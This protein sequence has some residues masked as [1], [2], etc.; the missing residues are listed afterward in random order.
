MK[1]QNKPLL[2]I[3]YFGVGDLMF[4][5]IINFS[6][7]RSY[8]SEIDA[9][10]ILYALPGYIKKIG[11]IFV[12]VSLVI[13]V[14]QCFWG[15]KLYR[16]TIAISGFITGSI[17]GGAIGLM[18]SIGSSADDIKGTIS[19]VIFTMLI[20]GIIGA[21]VAYQAEALGIFLVGFSGVYAVSLI[22]SLMGKALTNSDSFAA[23]FFTAAIPAV[24]AGIIVVKF[25]KPI[26]IIYTAL[27]GAFCIA[28]GTGFGILAFI[29]CSVGGIYYQIKSNN[30]LTEKSSYSPA[31][32]EKTTYNPTTATSSTSTRSASEPAYV[33]S[34][35]PAVSKENT[36]PD[37]ID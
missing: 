12:L 27:S 35:K 9:L 4:D 26:I 33:S 24:I 23:S 21:I 10:D 30:G 19:A 32:S 34:T 7:C 20:G 3:L 18:L 17:V 31:S 22:L 25:R 36:Y 11:F 6:N 37:I 15:Y 28:Y 14:I 29:A 16:V 5:Y 13:G 8:G 1:L 2:C